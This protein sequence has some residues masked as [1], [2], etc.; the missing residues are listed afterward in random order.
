MFVASSVESLPVADAIN[1]NFDRQAEVTVWK[2]G[3]QLSTDSIASLLFRA[4]ASDFAIFVFTPDDVTSIRRQEHSTVRDNVL[5]EL[6]LFIGSL[7]KER[8]FIVKPRDADLHIPTDLL[9]LTPADYEATRSDGNLAAAV[10]APCALITKQVEELGILSPAVR[11]AT[12]LRGKP[13][14]SYVI[15]PSEQLMMMKVLE[16]S[17]ADPNRAPIGWLLNQEKQR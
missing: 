15:G 4:R 11:K 5:F 1:V 7:G 8:C 3:F 14:Y 10:N 6:G 12:A 17:V 2:H 13:K 9:G 16:H